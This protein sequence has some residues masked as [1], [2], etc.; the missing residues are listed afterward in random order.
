MFEAPLTKDKILMN[1]M[2]IAYYSLVNYVQP[3]NTSALQNLDKSTN[4]N[5]LQCW[6]ILII[7][8]ILDQIK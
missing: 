6:P 1:R 3:N 8:F 4:W 5:I 7:Y 2:K